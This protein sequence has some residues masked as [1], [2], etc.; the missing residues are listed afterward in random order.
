MTHRRFYTP[1]E[2]ATHNSGNDCWVSIFHKV[3][4]LSPLITANRGPLAN[5]LIDAAGQ[6]SLCRTRRAQHAW[7][8]TRPCRAGHLPLV[9]RE[10]G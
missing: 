9:R 1:E 5:P 4:D 7:I 8:V 6:V 3:L 2:V 10:D